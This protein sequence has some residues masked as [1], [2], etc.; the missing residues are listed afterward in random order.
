MTDKSRI[1]RRRFL[2][3]LGGAVSATVLGCCG[4]TVLGTRAP[5]VE[6][7]QLTCGGEGEMSQEILVAYATKAGSTGEVADAIGRALC[8]GGAA[9]DVKPVK[10]VDDIG[11][12]RAVVV[13]SAIRIGRWLPEAVRFVEANAATLATMPVAFFQLSG[14]LQDDT[15]EKRQEAATY[16]APVRA[17]VEPMS[18]GLFAGKIEYSTL[19]F[20]DRTIA[21]LVGSAEG[22]WRDWEAIHAWATGLRQALLGGQ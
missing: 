5:E 2:G 11:G 4:M 21:K 18:E 17:L 19:S 13:G 22:D 9:V 3:L 14:F 7:K 1:T 6:L 16:L 20:F 8:D 10:E 12:Y 15:P